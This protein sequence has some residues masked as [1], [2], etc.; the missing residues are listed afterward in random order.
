MNRDLLLQDFEEEIFLTRRSLERVPDRFDY[1]PHPKSM[2]LGEL[3]MHIATLPALAKII[4]TEPSLD[5]TGPN[6]RRPEFSIKNKEQIFETFAETAD[7]LRTSLSEVT[8]QCLKEGWSLIAGDQILSIQPRYLVYRH[9]F[10]NHFVHHRAQLGV[11]L[12]LNEIP[13]PAT[14]GPS[15]DETP[16]FG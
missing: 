13:L 11:Y 2:S 8:D 7:S 9:L 3:A 4:L 14:Y 16:S 1:K 10:F 15:A 12:R 6:G 5:V